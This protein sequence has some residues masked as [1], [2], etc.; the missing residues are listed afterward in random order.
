MYD[1]SRYN[2]RRRNNNNGNIDMH[3][4]PNI[5][6][7]HGLAEV[8]RN[9]GEDLQNDGAIPY[10]LVGNELR[11][12]VFSP[13]PQRKWSKR[14]ERLS[15]SIITWSYGP[16]VDTGWGEPSFDLSDGNQNNGGFL[17]IDLMDDDIASQ[18][19]S[20]NAQ[21]EVPLVA[22]PTNRSTYQLVAADNDIQKSDQPAEPVKIKKTKLVQASTQEDYQ[23]STPIAKK[24]QKKYQFESLEAALDFWLKGLKIQER[25]K[26][27]YRT[28]IIRFIRLLDLK[29]IH[30]ISEDVI[31]E[32]VKEYGKQSQH[33]NSVPFRKV[34]NRFSDWVEAHR[35]Y[36]QIKP[37]DN[38]KEII[39]KVNFSHILNCPRTL[40]QHFQ[41]QDNL[42]QQLISKTLSTCFNEWTNTITGDVNSS[43]KCRT[44][45][46]NFVMFLTEI[47][48]TNPTVDNM[49]EYFENSSR[50]SDSVIT[51]ETKQ[52]I[53]SFLELLAQNGIEQDPNVYDLLDH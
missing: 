8:R 9:M 14:V 12:E 48:T 24:P 34:F 13:I 41:P 1:N 25:T 5:P 27:G 38:T 31:Q 6:S 11:P 2:Q 22:P 39:P 37:H 53:K 43:T 20:T 3:I 26:S 29:G 28:Q 33:L 19:N 52:A 35:I 16:I 50:N 49:I 17:P 30:R 47:K 36:N 51:K 21:E 45:V 42:M 4:Y 18:I 32:C 46:L 44:Q 15:K 40:H 10:F 7:A 23:T